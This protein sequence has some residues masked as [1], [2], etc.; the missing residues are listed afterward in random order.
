MKLF[1]IHVLWLLFLP[2]NSAL[3]LAPTAPVEYRLHLYHTHTNQTLDIV[4][5]RGDSYLPEALAKLDVFLRDHRTG[6]VS[7]FDPRL[8]DLLTALECSLGKPGAEIDV[9]CGYRTPWSNDYL[10]RTGHAVARHSMHM[11]AK[12]IDIRIPGIKTSR[13]RDAA[14]A[15]GQ[16]G[17][18]YYRARDFIHVD[19]GPVRRW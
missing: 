5:R 16:G 18:G 7:H 15:L 3:G 2:V 11:L 1:R 8:F 14:I 9:V 17:V 19:T 13:L 4:Y 10:R 6:D 12:A